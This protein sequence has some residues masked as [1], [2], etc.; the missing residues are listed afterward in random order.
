MSSASH[1][2]APHAS[3]NEDG[4][5]LRKIVIVGAVSLTIFALS[6]VAASMILD[7]DTAMLRET[8]GVPPAPVALGRPE[9]GIVD[10]IDF[11]SDHRLEVWRAERKARLHSYG[12]TDKSKGLIHIPIDKAMDELAGAQP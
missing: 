7:H 9:I 3:G 2:D 12:W 6:A 4:V 10:T 5:N 8:R 11:A 1:H